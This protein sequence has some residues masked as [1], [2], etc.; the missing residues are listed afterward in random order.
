MMKNHCLAKSIQDA[1][2]EDWWNSLNINVS[3]RDKIFLQVDPRNTT[4]DCNKCGHRNTELS[5]SDRT[6]IC[7]SCGR[8]ASAR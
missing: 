8:R 5:L 6:W 1:S 4:T 7:P 3:G 2:W